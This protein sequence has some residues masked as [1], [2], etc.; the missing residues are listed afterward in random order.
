MPERRKKLVLQAFRVL[1]KDG[2]GIVDATDVAMIYDAPQ[3]P[4]V[5]SGAKT[6]DAVL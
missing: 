1:D 3:H 2:S 6:K 5:L 4:M